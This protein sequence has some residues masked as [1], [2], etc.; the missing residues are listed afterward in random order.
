MCTRWPRKVVRSQAR[1]KSLMYLR[2]R[3]GFCRHWVVTRSH[4][5][6][7]NS[8][9]ASQIRTCVFS[10]GQSSLLKLYAFRSSHEIQRIAPWRRDQI[11]RPCLSRCGSLDARRHCCQ[12]NIG[13]WPLTGR[14][15]CVLYRIVSPYSQA[16]R[17]RVQKMNRWRT[18]SGTLFGQQTHI[19]LMCGPIC[20]RQWLTATAL[21]YTD[22]RK[23]TSF[24]GRLWLQTSFQFGD[25]TQL[26]TKWSFPKKIKAKRPH[27]GSLEHK[28]LTDQDLGQLESCLLCYNAMRMILPSPNLR[29]SHEEV[30]L[31]RILK[32]TN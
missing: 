6:R 19:E 5:V 13:Q 26:F 21:W 20:A 30:S 2:E 31:K 23:P 16:S 7:P 12:V 29:A 17:V 25:D 28:G 18:V 11:V 9:A 1:S 4:A 14:I 15:P 10:T 22:H 32:I 3:R 24:W 27:S 8:T